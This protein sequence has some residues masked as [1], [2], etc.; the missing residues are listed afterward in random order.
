[1]TN[2]QRSGI[3]SSKGQ[4]GAGV[5]R[6]VEIRDHVF[7]ITSNLAKLRKTDLQDCADKEGGRIAG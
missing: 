3:P 4:V 2:G 5:K 7:I 6:D 1:M